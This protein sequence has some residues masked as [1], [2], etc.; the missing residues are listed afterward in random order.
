M[1]D[2]N[3]MEISEKPNHFS[4]CSKASIIPKERPGLC[5]GLLGSDL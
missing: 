4:L 1:W 3:V 5:V 2:C